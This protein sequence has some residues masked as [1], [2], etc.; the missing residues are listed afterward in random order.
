MVLVAVP[1][2]GPSI[3]FILTFSSLGQTLSGSLTTSPSL[4]RPSSHLQATEKIL[5]RTSDESR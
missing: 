2:A 3:V 1:C 4:V 5:G